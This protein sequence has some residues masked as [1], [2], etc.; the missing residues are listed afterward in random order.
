MYL[1]SFLKFT[2]DC[3][4]LLSLSMQ[5]V[6]FVLSQS[7]RHLSQ[8]GHLSN[9]QSFSLLSCVDLLQIFP[10]GSRQS[11]V[12]FC[13][14]VINL[15]WLTPNLYLFLSSSNKGIIKHAMHPATIPMHSQKMIS[16]FVHCILI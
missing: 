4:L 2:Q 1:S 3:L 12:Y 15:D 11:F 14:H 10:E 6:K 8:L 5:V 9:L 7:V 16:R 13:M